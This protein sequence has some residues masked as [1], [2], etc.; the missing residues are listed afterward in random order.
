VT[1]HINAPKG[2]GPCAKQTVKA[3]IVALN[4]D[5]Y[6]GTNHCMKPK[7]TC[8]REGMPTGVGYD[9]C[10]RVCGQKAHAEV[11]AIEAAGESARGATLYLEGH[12][13][14]CQSCTDAANAAGIEE[15]VIGAPPKHS[16]QA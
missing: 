6:I 2:S 4:G 13:Y 1:I 11:N 12:T 9:L 5:H 10:V 3:T 14:A 15:I 8:I 16:P 7:S